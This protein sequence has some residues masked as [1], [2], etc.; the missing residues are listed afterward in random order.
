MTIQLKRFFGLSSRLLLLSFALPVACLQPG[1]PML[2]SGKPAAKPLIDGI[3]TA[4]P[5]AH[6]FDG[7]L[8]IYPS[9]DPEKAPPAGG[10]G[11]EYNMEDYH[12]FSMES[13]DGEVTD[14]GVALHVDD[15][16]WAKKQMWAPDAAHR[17]NLYYLYFPARDAAGIFRI[18]VAT[19]STPTGPF[20]AR[21]EPINRSFSIDPAVFIDEDG[22]AYMYFG[23]LWGGQLE[24]WSTG[25]FQPDG[26]GAGIGSPALGP[27]V[28]KMAPNLLEFEGP[29]SEVQI[30]GDKGTAILSSD[31]TKR[32]FEGAWVH[33][34]QGRYYLSYSTGD[35]HTIVYA[36]G[37]RPEGPFTFQGVL[38]EPVIG[39]TTHH[40]VVEFNGRWYIFYHDASLSG[41]VNHKR[42]VK[43]AEITYNPDGT[44]QTVV[45]E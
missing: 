39:W 15:V 8:Y 34:H 38:L 32:F 4:D 22:Q 29:V 27:R 3:Y 24:N 18:G 23:G 28:A 19:S 21:P 17:G 12:V 25:S 41:G 30:L 13:I 10:D 1:R 42:C 31:T 7:R 5:S 44:I 9:H 43:V 2:P 6:V 11:S 14:H 26:R 16:P 40:S 35:A 45:P 20:T 37:S 36:T 33:K